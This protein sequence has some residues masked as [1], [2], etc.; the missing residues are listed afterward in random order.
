MKQFL[1]KIL[2]SYLIKLK[3]N[4]N[5]DYILSLIHI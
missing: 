1:L 3:L 4:I 2:C 5:V